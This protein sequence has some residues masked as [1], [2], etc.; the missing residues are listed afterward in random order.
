MPDT[1]RLGEATIQQFRESTIRL[2]VE[3]A[4]E[5]TQRARR[6]FLVCI[7]ASLA[8]FITIYNTYISWDRRFPLLENFP[9]ND[10][11]KEVFKQLVRQYADST[12]FNVPLLGIHVA[13]SDLAFLGSLALLIL[14][15]WFFF[16]IRR[17]NHTIVDL[18]RDTEQ[19]PPDIRWYVFH[20]IHSFLVFTTLA[21]GDSPNSTPDPPERRKIDDLRW[22]V[23]LLIYLPAGVVAIVLF[24]I[25]LA[26]VWFRSVASYPHDQPL[27]YMLKDDLRTKLM[28]YI[29]ETLGALMC[30][31]TAYLCYKID[32]FQKRTADKLWEYREQIR[33]DEARSEV[34]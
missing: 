14:S 23:T 10:V 5:A 3:G 12:A 8:I 18:L 20:G 29:T 34:T 2:R 33:K 26:W 7:I 22:V 1:Q 24:A 16:S 4:Q 30:A 32:R 21:P 27:M 19:A 6:A 15:V 31:G 25:F 11:T 28:F 17:E 9:K 13:V